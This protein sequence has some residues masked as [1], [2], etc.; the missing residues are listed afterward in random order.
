MPVKELRVSWVVDADLLARFLAREH[1]AMHI[2][3]MQSAVQETEF[4]VDVVDDVPRLTQTKRKRK[5]KLMSRVLMAIKD[6]GRVKSSEI[7]TIIAGLGYSIHST[8]N[9]IDRMRKAKYLKKV[10]TGLYIITAKGV[11]HAEAQ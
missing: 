4:E 3:A 10:A 1:K 2:D 8:P 9:A 7:G 6:K 5:V 11:E